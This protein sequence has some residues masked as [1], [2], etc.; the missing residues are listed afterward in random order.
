MK[1]LGINIGFNLTVRHEEW[2]VSSGA[3]VNQWL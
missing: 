3:Q 2:E 1:S